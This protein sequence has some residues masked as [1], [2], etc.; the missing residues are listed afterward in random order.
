M[1]VADLL[2]PANCALGLQPREHGLHRGMRGPVLLWKRLLNLS[3]RGSSEFPQGFHDR[4]LER[5]KSGL[6]HTHP[7]TLV[8]ETTTTCGKMSTRDQCRTATHE[9]VSP[10]DARRPRQV[11]A[12]EDVESATRIQLVMQIGSCQVSATG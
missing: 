5:A 6:L 8:G 7:P 3:H 2:G 10:V 9:K 11:L 12:F 4:E 1:R